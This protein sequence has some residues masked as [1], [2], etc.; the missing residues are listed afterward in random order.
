[1]IALDTAAI[2]SVSSLSLCITENLSVPFFYEEN[3]YGFRN[4][5]IFKSGLRLFNQL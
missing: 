2:I 5:T 1:M 3:V 4:T